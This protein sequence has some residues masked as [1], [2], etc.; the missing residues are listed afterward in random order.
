LLI[1]ARSKGKAVVIGGG[2]LG[3][4][5]AAGLQM[6]GMDVTVLHLMPTLMERQL[7]E[8]AGYLLEKT[9]TERGINII[10]KANTKE[11]LG[12]TKVMGVR[13]EDGTE[14]E[15]DIVIMAVGIRPS[16]SLAQDAGL[17]VGRG[18]L[19]DCKMQTSDPDIYAVGECVEF[20][21]NCYGLVAPLYDQAKIVG[22]TLAEIDS[23][24]FVHPET[25]TKLKV[26]GVN[27]YSAGDFAEGEDR[28][29][30]VLRD[31]TQGIYKRLVLK[32]NTIIGVVLYGDT[33]DGPWFFQ[34]IK[35]KTD[36]SDMRE[37]LIFGPAYQG[38][39]RCQMIQKSAGVTACQNVILS[40]RLMRS[41][42][43][44]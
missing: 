38:G 33:E 44:A 25:A 13:L 24:G 42:W 43:G 32:D 31:A 12:D 1:A 26:T 7:D 16:K 2:L 3:L 5:A 36:I 40:M 8:S 11:I 30:I 15:A 35:D 6:Q 19:V 4:E 34:H 27:L 41:L 28:E 21:S 23:D 29:D 9:L 14:L 17:D 22:K 18:I 37:T 20:E 10:T 39:A